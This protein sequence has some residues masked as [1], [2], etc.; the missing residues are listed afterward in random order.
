MLPVATLITILIAAPPAAS[1]LPADVSPEIKTEPGMLMLAKLVASVT[2]FG[3]GDRD[4]LVKKILAT[5][6]LTLPAAQV[7]LRQYQTR[8]EEER[9]PWREHAAA[10][11]LALGRSRDEEIGGF[12]DEALRW[13]ASGDYATFADFAG[14]ETRAD[15]IAS[16]K[17]ESPL[18]EMFGYAT[19]LRNM[20]QGRGSFTMEFDKYD[21]VP[22]GLMEKIIRGGQ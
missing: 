22:E 12:L 2:E 18:G 1:F 4:L 6:T 16:I 13:D 17:A 7:W 14:M 8:P 19:S 11:I 21:P 15:G 10:M 3:Q 20:S 5:R 9:L